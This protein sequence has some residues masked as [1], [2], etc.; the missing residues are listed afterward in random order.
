MPP[1]S[2]FHSSGKPTNTE[3]GGAANPQHVRD[4]EL[5]HGPIECDRQQQ[6]DAWIQDHRN[7][8]DRP[9]RYS[10]NNPHHGSVKQVIND[11]H[12]DMVAP[13]ASNRAPIP[14]VW[15]QRIL[16]SLGFGSGGA[17]GAQDRIEEQGLVG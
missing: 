16:S 14:H 6:S 9:T 15:R 12:G 10:G 8:G 13:R 5:R 17:N 4:N 2:A 1:L 3:D 7:H 11:R